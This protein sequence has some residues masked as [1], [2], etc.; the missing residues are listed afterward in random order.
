MIVVVPFTMATATQTITITVVSAHVMPTI[1]RCALTV[2]RLHGA[3]F[4]SAPTSPCLTMITNQSWA[5]EAEKG[6]IFVFAT[7]GA[8]FYAFSVSTDVTARA[9]PGPTRL[10][11]VPR[12]G[13]LVQLPSRCHMFPC[14]TAFT[15]GACCVRM[16]ASGATFARIPIGMSILAR[17]TTFATPAAGG[18]FASGTTRAGINIATGDLPVRAAVAVVVPLVAIPA[19]SAAAA[20]VVVHILTCRTPATACSS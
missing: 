13:V 12:G 7:L 17:G 16:F 20:L 1:T 18:V 2:D 19:T 5:F 6:V 15:S 9:V 8:N 3:M 10:A 14:R 11:F 4:T